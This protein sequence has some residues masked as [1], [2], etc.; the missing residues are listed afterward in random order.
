M[1][2]LFCGNDYTADFRIMKEQLAFMGLSIPTLFKQ[3]SELCEEG[4]VRFLDFGVDADFNFC[5]D[6]LV[7]VDIEKV[8]TKKRLRYIGV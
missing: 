8:K 7:L 4:G 2:R 1:L 5:V 6:G 3:Y